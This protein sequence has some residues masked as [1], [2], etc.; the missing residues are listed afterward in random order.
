MPGGHRGGGVLALG[1]DEDQR[2]AGDVDVA[3]GRGLGPV[4]AHL[5]R[6]RD[7]VGAGGV[8]RLA[9]AH[10]DGGV[11][12][13]ARRA[14]PGY[15]KLSAF[16]RWSQ[17]LSIAVST[18]I[19]LPIVRY[20]AIDRSVS[21][22]AFRSGRRGSVPLRMIFLAAGPLTGAGLGVDPDDRPGRAALDRNLRVVVPA[23]VDDR[24][25]V[26]ACVI[27]P[28]A[29]IAQRPQAVQ[30]TSQSSSSSSPGLERLAG[31]PQAVAH[32]VQREQILG[33]GVDAV[34]AGRALRLVDD[35]QRVRV[36][37][38]SRRSRRPRRSRPRP[39][40]PQ[41]QP[42]P[43][44]AT[45]AAARQVVE[46]VVVGVVAGDVGAAGAG[47]PRDA[48]LLGADVDAEKGGDLRARPSSV[49]TVHL[50]G[51]ASPWTSASANGRQP[52]KPQAP[53][54]ACGSISSTTSMRGSSST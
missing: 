53:Q 23:V 21:R 24:Q 19:G 47:Q 2:P 50:P 10:D 37:A 43:P 6:G 27:R 38:G 28:G 36:H 32:R 40:Q 4:L 52:G 29:S 45:W 44:P 34:A 49:L 33:A 35:R 5:G 14:L 42:L 48:L 18:D 39:R 1:L 16:F 11:A 3:G 13:H 30:A 51:S 17:L 25:V 15:L 26:L 31:D 9:L 20:R 12:V 8:G 54:L 7:R 41:K 46:A 22:R